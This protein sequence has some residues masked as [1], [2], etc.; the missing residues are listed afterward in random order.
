MVDPNGNKSFGAMLL[1]VLKGAVSAIIGTV[2]QVVTSAVTY[3]GMAV[4]SIFDSDIRADMN[5]IGWNPFNT[6][7]MA[8]VNM[9]KVSFYKGIPAFRING[10]RSGTFAAMFLIKDDKKIDDVK[11]EWGHAIQ[12][13]IMG[14]ATFGLY[15]GIPSWKQFGQHKWPNEQYFNRPWETSADM[16]GGVSRQHTQEEKSRAIAYMITAILFGPWAYM[17]CA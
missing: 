16:I 7:E 10:T 17:F 5:A 4:A 9:N 12:Q 15:I 14:P 3:I 6:N 8:V 2:V 11:H 13:M 1:A